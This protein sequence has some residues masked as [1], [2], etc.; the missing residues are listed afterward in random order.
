MTTLTDKGKQDHQQDDEG[1]ETGNQDEQQETENVSRRQ[2]WRAAIA[3]AI[4]IS[5]QGLKDSE[6]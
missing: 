5:S 3:H 6:I 4:F 1:T 2:P